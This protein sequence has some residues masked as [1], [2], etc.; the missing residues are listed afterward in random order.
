MF[1]TWHGHVGQLTGADDA[2][3]SIGRFVGDRL[4]E[5][6]AFGRARAT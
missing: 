5:N 6:A 1:H 4:A 2:I 3:G